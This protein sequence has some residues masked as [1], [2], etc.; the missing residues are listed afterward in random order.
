M[1]TGRAF[2]I[3]QD[4]ND[5]SWGEQ[6]E[7]RIESALRGV[8]FLIPIVTPSYFQSPACRSEFNTFLMREKELGEERLILPIYYVEC[9]E[10]DSNVETVDEI[11]TVLKARNWADWRSSRFK[12]LTSPELRE[13]ISSLATTIKITIK[14]L[15]DVL[16]ASQGTTGSVATGIQQTITSAPT[17]LHAP[18][19]SSTVREIRTNPRVSLNSTIYNEVI[20]CPYYA[21]T[22][23]YDE[24]T[25]PS[26]IVQPNEI[27]E[28]Y[29]TLLGHIR[30]EMESSESTIS[31]QSTRIR[32][33]GTNERISIMFLIDNSGSM[34][35]EKILGIACWISIISSI[36]A[37]YN[38]SNEVVGFTTRAWKGGNSRE[39]WLKDGKPA[40]PGRLNDVR[41]VIYK[42]FEQTQQEA[43]TNFGMMIREGL[44]KEN[45]DGEALLWA[46][47]RLSARSEKRKLLIVLSDGAPVD[48]STLSVNP[49]NFLDTHCRA[50]INWIRSKEDIEL[51]GIGVEFD[52]YRYY[53][54]K[55]RL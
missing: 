29:S 6:W 55:A 51:Y 21:Y 26:E 44:L 36:L 9:D 13:K 23:F 30:Q 54:A 46:F 53:G 50:A 42:S 19:V 38:I 25:T 11:A 4:R 10:M 7:E 45:I 12:E 31:K 3:F 48:N 34:R 41:Y 18:L 28:L 47:S 2:H 1:Q 14:T 35:G 24:E 33:I 5:I 27:M 40:R 52:V 49:G 8:T 22:T 39:L 16:A 17:A 43:D 32:Q 37:Q 15:E 20:K